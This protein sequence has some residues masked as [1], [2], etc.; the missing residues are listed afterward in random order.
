MGMDEFVPKSRIGTNLLL[1]VVSLAILT[2]TLA[3]AM[4]WAERPNEVRVNRLIRAE[5]KRLDWIGN[6]M[7]RYTF[8][9]YIRRASGVA[10]KGGASLSR[11]TLGGVTPRAEDPHESPGR[12]TPRRLVL[13]VRERRDDRSVSSLHEMKP[14]THL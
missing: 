3:Y 9:F 2:E 10:P 1:C 6:V 14:A 13:D 12:T 8:N 4:Q 11:L 5:N 7:L